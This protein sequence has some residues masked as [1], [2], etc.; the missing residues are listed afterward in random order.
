M[1]NAATW[2]RLREPPLG[3][4]DNLVLF[5][6]P[7]D[8]SVSRDA[9]TLRAGGKDSATLGPLGLLPSSRLT[10]TSTRSPH[11]FFPTCGAY[12]MVS[13]IYNLSR[14]QLIIDLEL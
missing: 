3:Q 5:G 7:A 9:R 1:I 10:V 12:S 14:R 4:V 8:R 6:E 13:E 2:A 11:S